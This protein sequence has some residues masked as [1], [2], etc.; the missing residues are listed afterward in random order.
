[1]K[2]KIFVIF[3]VTL[4]ISG[5][6]VS[7]NV[8]N[9]NCKNSEITYSNFTLDDEKEICFSSKICENRINNLFSSEF[10]TKKYDLNLKS[11][12]DGD[13]VPTDIWISSQAEDWDKSYE[14]TKA[15]EGDNIYFYFSYGWTGSE[16]CPTHAVQFLLNDQVIGEGNIE[17]LEGGKGIILSL[18]PWVSISGEYK[19]VAK[20]DTNNVVSESDENNNRL[21]LDFIV[22]GEG[23]SNGDLIATNIWISSQEDDWEQNHII[24]EPQV[25]QDIYFYFA[26]GWTGTETC[27]I[28]RVELTLTGQFNAKGDIEDLPAG[29][30]I[31]VYAGPW[32]ASKGDFSYKGKTDTLNQV[33]ETDETN[34]ELSMQV[35]VE[36]YKPEGDLIA[37]ETWLSLSA[38]DWDKANKVDYA[39]PQ[40]NHYLHFMYVWTGEDVCPSHKV[41]IKLDGSLFGEGEVESIPAENGIVMCANRPYLPSLLEIGSTHYITGLTDVTNCIEEENEGNN[42]CETAFNV[43]YS[44]G[45]YNTP[46]LERILERFQILSEFLESLDHFF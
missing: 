14:I 38:N 35:A 28:H 17:G 23:P 37:R 9:K 45:K 25:G 33:E 2:G 46:N 34:N 29:K 11:V 30:A 1:M 8:V 32:S 6:F 43:R 36:E 15:D 12:L 24:T 41:Q 19:Y 31:A 7:A 4:L 27:P 10:K 22:E 40:T 5:S 44:R 13:L 21:S 18:G 20:V 39:K 16:T 42:Q 26:Y 3:F